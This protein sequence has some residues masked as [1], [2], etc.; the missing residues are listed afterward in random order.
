L[1]LYPFLEYRI[2]SNWW[3]IAD[4]F[5]T[6]KWEWKVWRYDIKLQI[7]KPTLDQPTLGNF[8]VIF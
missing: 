8:T 7:Q 4:R 2:V 6:V 1:N 3:K 5:Y